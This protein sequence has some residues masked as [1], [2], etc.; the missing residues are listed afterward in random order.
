LR[1]HRKLSLHLFVASIGFMSEEERRK[2]MNLVRVSKFE[3]E[4]KLKHEWISVG[5]SN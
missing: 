4:R 1:G 5:K 2:E 3:S